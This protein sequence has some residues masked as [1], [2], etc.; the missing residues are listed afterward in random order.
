MAAQA[1]FC[2]ASRPRIK[3]LT[4]T[5]YGVFQC[6]GRRESQPS[7]RRDL[8]LRPCRRVTPHPRLGFA[9]AENPEAGKAQRP[10]ALELS[11]HE[12]GNFVKCAFRLLLTDTD[13]VGQM[14]CDL[15]LRHHPPPCAR[16]Y[17][18]G[19]KVGRLCRILQARWA[20]KM[21]IFPKDQ[22]TFCTG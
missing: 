11:H 13:F 22:P 15:R 7:A 5:E 1:R 10:F 2:D 12:C 19:M 9:L 18:P 3:G 21:G 14:A 17:G 6:L 8:N 16:K 4:G 20:V